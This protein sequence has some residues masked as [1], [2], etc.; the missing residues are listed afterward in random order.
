MT[1]PPLGPRA[2]FLLGM[3][4]S[5]RPYLVGEIVEVAGR[6]ESLDPEFLALLSEI[7]GGDV[8]A[9]LAA[10]SGDGPERV[11]RLLERLEQVGLV[12]SVRVEGAPVIWRARALA[13]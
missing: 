1:A 5:G 4:G 12:E 11:E 8:R 13:R 3:L 2:A 7:G 10:I 6:A 9:T